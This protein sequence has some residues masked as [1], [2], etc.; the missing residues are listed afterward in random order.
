MQWLKH[1]FAVDPPGPAQPTDEQLPV[2]E[3]LCR[4]IVRRRLTVPALAGLEMY[5]PLNSLGSQ[6]L[7]F[8]APIIS[9]FTDSVGHRHIATFLERRGSVDFLCQRIEAFESES[10]VDDATED[11]RA[12]QQSDA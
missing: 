6:F 8:A 11:S 4:E 5:R 7:H 10:Q 3:R 2:V 12:S 9:S 1:A